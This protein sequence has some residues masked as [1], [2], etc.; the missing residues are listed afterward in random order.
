MPVP[1]MECAVTFLHTEEGGRRT[2]FP[3]DALSGGTYRPHLV[4][5]DPGQRTAIVV[6][7]QGI[8][9]LIGV[10]FHRGPS[11]VEPG[12][13]AHFVLS[14]MFHPHQVY[15]QLQPGVTFTVREGSHVVGFG[16]VIRRLAAQV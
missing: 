11:V 13:E 15:E 7:N 8:E 3:A 4:I 10:A 2:R 9:E 1:L 14:L 12:V 16:S 6:G 5:G